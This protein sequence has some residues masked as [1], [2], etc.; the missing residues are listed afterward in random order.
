M[1][2]PE[3]GRNTRSIG[4]NLSNLHK[5]GLIQ[6]KRRK[7]YRIT[8]AGVARALKLLQDIEPVVSENCADADASR[9]GVRSGVFE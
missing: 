8:D 1:R 3:L 7:G 4:K 6:N 5:A 2:R 9:L